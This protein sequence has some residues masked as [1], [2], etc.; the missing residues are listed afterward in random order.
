MISQ[1]INTPGNPESGV[2]RKRK[3]GK[4]GLPDSG[5]GGSLGRVLE[6][7]EVISCGEQAQ[8]PGGGRPGQQEERAAPERSG[9]DMGWGV[10]ALGSSIFGEGCGEWE[11]QPEHL[12][13]G[14][15]TKFPGERTQCLLEEG[16]GGW[17]RPLQDK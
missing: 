10:G 11:H 12:E 6:V 4:A 17:G 16:E 13:S 15:C 8:D 5:W 14:V 3:L 7:R 2:K 9:S 1:Q